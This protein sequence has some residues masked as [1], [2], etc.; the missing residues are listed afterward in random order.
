MKKINEEGITLIA[1]VVTIIV[2]FILAGVTIATL[3]G[4]NGISTKSII[5]KENSEKSALIEE[6]KLRIIEEQTEKQG[7]IDNNTI[8]CI[9]K[10][11]GEINGDKLRI[12][13]KNYEINI[14]DIWYQYEGNK[15]YEG[16]TISILGD[17]IST[18]KGY[19][20]T[21][22]RARYVQTQEEA[23]GGLIYMDY[24]TTYWGGLIEDFKM[25]LGINESWAGSR[26][27]NTATTNSGD[28]GPDRAISSMTRITALGDNGIPDVILFYG[29]TNDIG[30]KVKIGTFNKETVLDTTSTII[31]N[32][33]DAYS[34]T[35]LRLK[36]LYP[37]AEIITLLPTVT[38]SYYTTTLLNQYDDLMVQICNYYN[39]KYIDLRDCGITTS[40]LADGIH[41]TAEGMKIIKEYIREQMDSNYKKDDKNEQEKANL[42][43][44]DN[45]IYGTYGPTGELSINNA[46]GGINM[47]FSVSPGKKVE[48]NSFGNTG[49]NGGGRNGIRV[50]YFYDNTIIKNIAPDDVY[51]EYSEHGYL[52]I[53]EGVNKIA[54]QWWSASENNYVYIY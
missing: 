46:P 12:T 20:P 40:N 49:V 33:A 18:L 11:Y 27:S 21:Q 19:I 48:A 35:I 44:N 17:S 2:L 3:T 43:N 31:D 50:V 14:K 38:S 13:G 28:V 47:I 26:V 1:L 24:N 52:T 23:T 34:Q 39:I 41:P 42:Y 45:Y 15:S 54:V 16:K 37:N 6:I 9:L 7:N 22:N 36:Y 8:E 32:F 29:G 5:S 30:N 53:P 25:K 51:R 4:E 10:G